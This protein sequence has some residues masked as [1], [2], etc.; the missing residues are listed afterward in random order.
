MD[1][2]RTIE[3]S[4]PYNEAVPRVKEAFQ[5]HARSSSR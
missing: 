1:Y 5:E 2:G 3:L 4:L